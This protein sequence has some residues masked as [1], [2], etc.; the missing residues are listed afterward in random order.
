MN[1][2][3]AYAA[4]LLTVPAVRLI[5]RF[6]LVRHRCRFCR[7]TCAWAPWGYGWFRWVGS[8]IHIVT[9]PRC[10]DAGDFGRFGWKVPRLP[11]PQRPI[12]PQRDLYQRVTFRGQP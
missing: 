5:A 12:P 7:G 1:L 2:V 8:Y 3:I 6:D 11:L 4:G 10:H 9:H